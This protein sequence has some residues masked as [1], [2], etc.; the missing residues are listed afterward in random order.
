MKRVLSILAAL[1][2]LLHVDNFYVIQHFG[3]KINL[4]P[5]LEFE[6]WTI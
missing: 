4:L 1:F 2:R 6:P 3:E 5:I